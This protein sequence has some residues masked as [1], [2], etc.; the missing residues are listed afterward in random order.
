MGEVITISRR[1]LLAGSATLAATM[2]ACTP[3]AYADPPVKGCWTLAPAASDDFTSFDSGRWTKGLWYATSGVGAFNPA[4]VTLTG[5]ELELT[6]KLE[7]YNGMSY[8]FGAVESTFD[9]PGA[10]S[11]VEV[12]AKVLDSAA[13]VLSAIWMQSS[14]LSLANNP[15]P[16]IDIQETFTYN[17]VLTSLHRW[18]MA[19]P[20][21]T[22]YT[23]HEDAHERYTTRVA[24][25]SDGYHVYG[26][27]R[28]NG[29]LRSY[30]DNELVWQVTPRDVAYLTLPRHLV[31]SL[32]GHLGQPVDAHLPATFRIDYV[33]TYVPCR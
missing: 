16:E 5:G 7:T 27:E 12:R 28:N 29:V 13:N 10:P 26:L 31:L 4:N 30:F 23:H 22:N 6:A 1:T 17:Q 15:N 9:V 25:S 3:N 33:H 8:T 32:E 11:Y 2:L 19:R 20:G 14:P 21:D 24:D 18:I